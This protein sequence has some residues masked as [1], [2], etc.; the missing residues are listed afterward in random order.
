[1]FS[2][3]TKFRNSLTRPAGRLV[4]S[5]QVAL[6]LALCAVT[7]TFSSMIDR[8]R[9][10]GE[11]LL[12]NSDF[13]HHLDGWRKVG[14]GI[15]E[16]DETNGSMRLTS[17]YGRGTVAVEQLLS[18]VIPTGQPVVLSAMMKTDD[19][20]RGQQV[21]E[22]ARIIFVGMDERGKPMY[23][24]P[25]ALAMRNG[26]ADWES[27]SKVFISFA[28]TSV[29]K[30]A[31]QLVNV[32]GSVSVRE[33][34]LKPAAETLTYRVF[35]AVDALLWVAV[36]AWLLV[37][38]IRSLVSSRWAAVIPLLLL[39]VLVGVLMPVDVKHDM[40]GLLEPA[41]S[42]L[43]GEPEIFRAG[44]FLV[45]TLLGIAVFWMAPSLRNALERF[46]LLA[47]FALITETLQVLVD[48]RTFRALDILADVA[49]IAFGLVVSLGSIL[50]NR[51]VGAK[52]VAHS[53]GSAPRER[54]HSN[55]V[56]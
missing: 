21:W 7:V 24:V 12:V 31:I 19:V 26:T 30:L 50:C 25:H 47:L 37:P 40:G 28:N 6:V 3:V 48:G 15:V 16:F 39:A 38:H 1:M 36:V 42:W 43:G 8:Y 46:W 56:D 34:S 23:Y 2:F 27:Y 33:L 4:N 9:V 13:T 51:P 44:H 10:S 14:D 18:G 22:A 41:L 45:F 49:G 54:C 11:E 5:A 52:Q 29:Q 17:P 53:A 20:A 35:W 55:G 32:K